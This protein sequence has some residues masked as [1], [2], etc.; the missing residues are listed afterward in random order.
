MDFLKLIPAAAVFA[1]R[2]CATCPA[3][4]T[5]GG[6]GRR[7]TTNSSR[8]TTSHSRSSTA[9][10]STST[11]PMTSFSSSGSTSTTTGLSA[12]TTPSGRPFTLPGTAS[13]TSPQ[14]LQKP[15]TT[16]A[17][18]LLRTSPA[19]RSPCPA[20]SCCRPSRSSFTTT[21]APATS[22]RP[23]CPTRLSRCARSM[24]LCARS[25]SPRLARLWVSVCSSCAGHAPTPSSPVWRC[26]RTSWSTSTTTSGSAC[27][28]GHTTWFV[29]L[30]TA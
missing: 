25:S 18:C 12:M 17:V 29:L 4:R 22:P 1:I 24:L 15:P 8:C 2:S 16:S 27:S 11:C 5:P 7:S 10:S 9:V 21:R 30:T 6:S 3:A 19:G 20:R 13:S 23:C 26:R 28:A 14:T